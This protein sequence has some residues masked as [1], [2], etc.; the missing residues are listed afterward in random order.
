MSSLQRIASLLTGLVLT[1]ALLWAASADLA[2]NKSNGTTTVAQG[3][4][5]TYTILVTNLGPD[6]VSGA[7]VADNPPPALGSVT[8]TCIASPGASCTAGGSG[9]LSDSIVL[10]AGATVTYSLTGTVST[11]ATGSLSNT[12]TVVSPAGTGDPVPG[13]NSATDTD[14]LTPLVDLRITKTDGRTTAVPGTTLSYTVVV[15]NDGPQAAASAKVSDLF[16][17]PLSCSWRCTPS[18][19]ASCNAGPVAGI[20]DDTVSLPATARVTYTADCA[21]DPAATGGLTNNASVI[22]ASGTTE[23]DLSDNLASDSTTLVPTADLAVTITDDQ[24]VAVP[25][26]ADVTYTV[27]VRNDGPSD[28]VGAVVQDVFPPQLSGITWTCL[29]AGGASCTAAGA[30]HLLDTVDL[31]AGTNVR[32]FATGSPGPGT[33]GTLSNTATVAAPATVVESNESNNSATDLTTLEPRADLSLLK[34]DGVAT[35]T[36][37]GTLVYTLT[38]TNTGPSNAP[39]TTVSDP[40]PDGLGCEWTCSADPGANCTAGPPPGDLADT[41]NLPTGTSLVYTGSCV[42]DPAAT[43]T[44]SNTATATAPAGV[45]ELDPANNQATDLTTLE[46]VADLR[47]SKDDGLTQAIPGEGLTYTLVV[48]N[49]GPSAAIDARVQDVFPASLD[50][51]WGCA[52]SGGGSCTPGQV[53]GDL[54]ELVDLPPGAELVYTAVCEIAPEAVGTLSNT[55]TVTPPAGV[56]DPFPADATATDLDTVLQPTVDLAVSLSGAPTTLSPGEPLVYTLVVANTGPSDA[57]GALLTD[58][59]PTELVDVSWTCS[60][61]AGSTCPASG[62]GDLAATVTVAAAGQLTA[63]IEATV[64]SDATGSV[65]NTATVASAVGTVDTDS[66]NNTATATTTLEPEADLALT[67]TDG[68]TS[69]IPGEPLVYTL[70]V[71]NHGPADVVDALLADSFP[72]G[73]SDITWN[74]TATPGSSCPAAGTG[75]LAELVTVAADGQLTVL[76]STTLEP[77]AVGLLANTATITPPA[78]VMDPVMANN[79]ASDTDTQ[80]APTADLVVS[81]DDGVESATPGGSL[82]YTLVVTNNGPSN[83]PNT[84]VSTPLATGLGCA[85]SCVSADGAGC[86]TVPASGDLGALLDLPA[87]SHVTL[88]A[89]CT[90]AA[91]ATGTL[92]TTATASPGAGVVDPTPADATAL[93]TTPLVPRADLVIT[94]TDGRNTIAPGGRLEYTLTVTN[95]GG[96]SHVVGATVEDDFPATLDCSWTC[97]AQGGGSCTQGQ[98]AGDVLDVVDLPVGARAVYTALCDVAPD[99]AGTVVNTATVTTPAGT[100]ETNAS[101]NAALDSTTLEPLVDLAIVASDGV[102][103]AIPGESLTYTITVT[104]ALGPPTTGASVRDTFPAALDCLWSCIGQGGGICTPGQVAGDLDDL[105]DLPAGASVTY[106]AECAIDPVATGSMSNTAT[107]ELTAGSHDPDPSN[108]TSSDLDTVLA[109]RADLAITK[110]DGRTEA[111]PGTELVYTVRVDNPGPSSAAD[112]RVEDPLPPTLDCVWTCATLGGAL[113]DPGPVAGDLLDFADLPAGSSATY[114]ATCQIDPEAEGTLSNTAFLTP[115]PGFDDPNPGNDSATDGDTD[116]VLL[117]DLSL[118]LDDAMTTAV[119]GTS[120]TYTLVARHDPP[121]FFTPLALAPWVGP[122]SRRPVSPTLVDVFP[123]ALDCTWTCTATPGSSCTVGPVMGDLHDEPSLEVGGR[124]TYTLVCSVDPSITGQLVTTAHLTPP[125]GVDDL[126][127]ANNTASDTNIL[128]PQA[129]LV[130][131]KSD[132]LTQATPGAGVV[133]TLGVSNNGPSDA[134]G[135]TLTD[136]VAPALDCLWS[137]VASGGASCNA[138]QIPGHLVETVNLPAGSTATFTGQCVIDPGAVGTLVN[139]ASA[140][141]AASVTELDPSNNSASDLD[142]V[143]VPSADLAITKSDGRSEATPGEGLVYTLEVSNAEGPSTLRRVM[144]SD[145]L[146]ATLDCLWGCVGGGGAV[147]NPGQVAGNVLDHVDLPPGSTATYTLDCLIDPAAE[148]LLVNTATVAAPAG[149]SDPDATNNSA[150]DDDTQ[151]RPRADLELT[152][153]D[154]TDQ[155]I[156]GTTLVYTVVASNVTGPSTIRGV[157]VSDPFPAILDCTWTCIPEGGAIC[158]LGPVVGDLADIV[159][160]P[161]GSRAV[162]SAECHVGPAAT[163]MLL[164]QAALGLP[165]GADDPDPNNNVA[166]DLDTLQPLADLVITKDDGVASA[167][168]GEGLSYTITARNDGPSHAPGSAVSDIVPASLVC[169]WVCES[170]G[171]AS[172]AALAGD[173]LSDTPDL[174]AGAQVIYT[175][176]CSIDPAATGILANTATVTAAAGILEDDP[177]NNN[178]SDLDTVLEPVADLSITKSDGQDSALPGSEVLYTLTVANAGPSDARGVTVSDPFP[179]TLTC[180]WSCVADDDGPECTNGPVDG[181]LLDLIDL[182]VGVELTY[183]AACQIDAEAQGEVS[184]TATIDGLPELDPNPSNNSATDLDLLSDLAD[185]ALALVDSPD[186]VAPAATLT[187]ALEIS[188]LGPVRERRVRLTDLLPGQVTLTAAYL[189]TPGLIFADGFESGNTLA[190]GGGLAVVDA[191]DEVGGTVSCD[192]GALRVDDSVVLVLEVTVD[193]AASGTLINNASVSGEGTDPSS[194]NDTA[195]ELTT[196]SSGETAPDP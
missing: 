186:P 145:E 165:D 113:C 182:P 158:T 178:A 129:D 45:I 66:A 36:P 63:T 137:C 191:C 118:T 53:A 93:H 120:V 196:V 34:S 25:G 109:P 84:T 168:P 8:W 142:T 143:L 2:I 18:G 12:A 74:C 128:T 148:G 177:S 14:P 166:S 100:T 10:P 77:N 64:A 126:L 13:N 184:N 80:L 91:G 20:L 24:T 16:P 176:T 124:A 19:G 49:D 103:T 29:A 167:T 127:L 139:T 162:Y 102:T 65:S 112:V 52:A 173:D 110:T 106:T 76:A 119:P 75:D 131:S 130:V 185:L 46:P 27:T 67:K 38:V 41:V 87:A 71:T 151:L 141:V 169:S 161:A 43:G 56:L 170:F 189:A 144:V 147:C 11:S 6:P 5:L 138:G 95:F 90:L 35:A 4:T 44:L 1:P 116:L 31:P 99:A 174:P 159:D 153:D 21:I 83:A 134:P 72:A 79:T 133:Y 192:L 156:P 190:W 117:A 59:L 60:A 78:G 114:T 42:I 82:V 160:L 58:T 179:T 81:L 121:V 180:S 171:G 125:P 154:G 28:V 32:Y 86:T 181:D 26:G 57:V 122:P 183:V 50:C 188:N 7:A 94:K 92:S 97:V 157:T 48:D 136:L 194:A 33:T 37:G 23:L 88:T 193:S 104:N 51:L 96:P 89:E 155:A 70:T 3:Q 163:G 54:D 164:N 108:N 115:P 149:S 107:V 146:P 47:I 62:S 101:N 135:T 132:G 61:T 73:L 187:Y 123:Q 111:N 22:V 15:T 105:A 39:G 55:A 40:L 152:K 175:G 150:T 85:W 9:S 140:E 68:A 17:G 69:A 30:G 98:V 172:C 195:V